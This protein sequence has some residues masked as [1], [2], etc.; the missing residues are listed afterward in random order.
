M[1]EDTFN[2]LFPEVQ[3]SVCPN[4]IQNFRN[5]IADISILGQFCTYLQFKGEKK[6]NTFIITNANDCPNLLSYGATFRIGVLLLNYPKSMVVKGKNVPHFQKMSC[7]KMRALTGPSNV[8]QILNQLQKQQQVVDQSENPVKSISFRI[9][10]P[11]KSASKLKMTAT[12]TPRNNLPTTTKA[13]PI[14]GTAQSGCP[15]PSTHVHKLLK[16]VLKPGDSVALQ[17][18]KTPNNGRTSV[19]RLPLMK[20]NILSHYSNCFEG[21]GQFPGEPNFT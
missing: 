19:T 14:N 11:S 21:I 16:W 3:F 9:T 20:Q 7:D 2:E 12:G 10:T 13:F 17:K 4:E 6:Q 8:F 18:V 1:N 5:S 15:A